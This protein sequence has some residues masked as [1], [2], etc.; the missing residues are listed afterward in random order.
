[1][2]IS[3]FNYPPGS[4]GRAVIK[5]KA[6]K[7]NGVRVSQLDTVTSAL[8]EIENTSEFWEQFI[9]DQ[10]F[11]WEAFANRIQAYFRLSPNFLLKTQRK[12]K[13][14]L[15]THS[16][17]SKVNIDAIHQHKVWDEYTLQTDKAS[18]H[19][20][21][22]SWT[23]PSTSRLQLTRSAMKITAG[24]REALSRNNHEHV[25]EGSE[26]RGEETEW[27]SRT[28][29]LCPPHFTSWDGTSI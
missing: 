21:G 8:W 16:T 20:D 13:S 2:L 15:R 23:N 25:Q 27:R 29:T 12:K 6:A 11:V 28:A 1:M 9:R 3:L 4:H 17:K 18:E 14:S 5:R 22:F 10:Y 24:P 19:K 26:G 7:M